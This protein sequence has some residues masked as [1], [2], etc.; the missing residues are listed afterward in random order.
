MQLFKYKA[1][2]L[3][4]KIVTVQMKATEKYFLV[5]LF[6]VECGSNF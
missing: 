5:V 3:F 2:A 1:A 6:A 4:Y